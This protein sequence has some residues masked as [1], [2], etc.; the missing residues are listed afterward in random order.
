V[1][2]TDFQHTADTTSGVPTEG[3]I[4]LQIHAGKDWSSGSKVRYRDIRVTEL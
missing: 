4:G 3:R 1:A 2:I